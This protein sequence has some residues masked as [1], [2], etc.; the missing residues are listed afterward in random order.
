M[1]RAQG[2]RG[3]QGRGKFRGGLDQGG[4]GGLET[5]VSELE[6]RARVKARIKGHGEWT[7][8]WDEKGIREEVKGQGRLEPEVILAVRER[9]RYRQGSR[10]QQSQGNECR[11]AG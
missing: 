1:E 8:S 5:Q 11:V 9:L 10:N 6:V 2:N 3:S 7:L 4:L